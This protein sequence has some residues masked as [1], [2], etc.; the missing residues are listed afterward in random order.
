MLRPSR[1]LA[2]NTR[3]VRGYPSQQTEQYQDLSDD[4]L[5]PHNGRVHWSGVRANT[6]A[7]AVGGV[8]V[9]MAL[10]VL[11][12]YTKNYD[13]G[14]LAQKHKQAA[15]DLWLVRESYLSLLVDL[16]MKEKPIEA[17]QTQRDALV[18]QLHAVCSGSPSTTFKAYKKA[19]NA[20]QKREDMTFSDE[21]IDAF[22]PAQLRRSK[23]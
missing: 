8:L 10:L 20:L 5:R 4:S 18:S 17:L 13:L 6:V 9:S 22:L 11:T 1:V 21:E 2:Q 14:E 12:A 23:I 3:E 19:Q 7:S 16:A 15:N